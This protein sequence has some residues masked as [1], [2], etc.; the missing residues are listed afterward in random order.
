MIRVESIEINEVWKSIESFKD[1]HDKAISSFRVDIEK[2]Y[3]WF[4][5]DVL[6]STILFHIN[7]TDIF[8][9]RLNKEAVKRAITNIGKMLEIT[10]KHRDL[11]K[12]AVMLLLE[13]LLVFSVLT[14]FR[15]KDYN[16]I[17]KY[18]KEVLN[19][20]RTISDFRPEIIKAIAIPTKTE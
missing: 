18:E 10:R 11:C 3:K 20:A 7:L 4:D 16:F 13:P 8:I 5:D 1:L 9:S 15:K 6:L 17:L 19:A 14:A 2:A 12:S